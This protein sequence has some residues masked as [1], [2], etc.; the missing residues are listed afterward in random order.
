M[1]KSSWLQRWTRWLGIALLLT[2]TL[3]ARAAGDALVWDKQTKRV[4]AEINAWDLPRVLS[5]L[6][7]AAGW[8]VLVEPGTQQTTTVRFKNLTV[9]EA[10]KRLLGE[11]NYALLPQTNGP[12]KLFVFRTTLQEATQLIG[13][14]AGLDRPAGKGAIPNELIV[15]LRPKSKQ[16]IEALARALGAKVI[17]KVDGL[18]TYRLQFQ[19]ETAA[20]A[21]RDAL[22]DDQDVAATDSN[23]PVDRPTRMDNVELS[24]AA[25]F[26]L[27]PK[28]GNAGGQVVVAL[29]DTPVQPLGAGM[30]EFMLPP[31]HVAGEPAGASEELTHGTSMAETILRG[32]TYAPQENGGSSVRVL[33]IDVYG[34]N[35]DTTTFDVAKGIYAALAAGATIVNLSLGGD[36]DSQ[37]LSG[38]IREAHRQGVLFF[39]AAGNQPTTYPT[40]PAAY[41]EVVAVTAGDRRGNIAPYA[42]RGSFVDV[43]APGVSLVEY[44]GSS[45]LVRGTSAATAYVSGTAAG[46]RAGGSAPADVET[47]IRQNLAIRPAGP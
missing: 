18:N 19:N 34:N 22:A 9:G 36:G 8:Q 7:K 26:A 6:A 42:N 13:D 38:L 30:S 12:A 39:G 43:I 11:L 3:C 25:P 33:P 27:K 1:N 32:L 47:Y 35:A 23:Y 21:A 10:L 17:G 16:S 44:Q 41:P 15:T 29:I 14:D 40:F 24:S 4:D 28:L 5:S 31:V 2:P 20:Q 37:F 46:I 45:Y